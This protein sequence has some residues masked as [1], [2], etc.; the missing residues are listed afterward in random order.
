MV[1]V[2]KSLAEMNVALKQLIEVKIP[3]A[4]YVATKN[5]SGDGSRAI[6]K[7]IINSKVTFTGKL[8]DSITI[9]RN[10]AARRHT[11][12]S[13][14]PYAGNIELGKPLS[15]VWLAPDVT[16]W[17]EAKGLPLGGDVN[18]VIVGKSGGG[19]RIEGKPYPDGVRMFEHGYNIING[20]IVDELEKELRK[21]QA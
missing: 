20:R 16:K 14:V 1:R 7:A 15:K 5:V 13:T 19:N 3:Q 9:S 12:Y 6:K 2:F 11:I 17:R 21:I 8:F 4:V 18:K 10:K